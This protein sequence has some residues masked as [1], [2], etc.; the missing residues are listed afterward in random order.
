MEALEE[1]FGRVQGHGIDAVMPS[2]PRHEDAYRNSSDRKDRDRTT[3]S[4]LHMFVLAAIGVAFLVCMLR[5]RPAVQPP[6]GDD[7]DPLF[8]PF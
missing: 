8:Q 3:K 1:R 5:S 7:D 6:T 2:S 4:S